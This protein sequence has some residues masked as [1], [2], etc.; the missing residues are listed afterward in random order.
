MDDEINPSDESC[1][2]CG[3][4]MVTRVCGA[5]GGEGCTEPG[6]L[7]EQDP[8]WYDPDDVEQCCECRGL[9]HHEWCQKCGWDVH[10]NG[11]LNGTPAIPLP[12]KPTCNKA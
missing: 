7:Y 8:L 11:F 4:G 10:S 12:E 1:P 6:E 5:C 2:K 3:N 9:G